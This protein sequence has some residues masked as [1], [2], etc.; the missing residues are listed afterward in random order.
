MLLGLGLVQILEEIDVI[1]LT[2]LHGTESR[3]IDR[4]TSTRFATTIS[5][6][7]GSRGRTSYSTGRGFDLDFRSSLVYT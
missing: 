6:E 7:H 2:F 5:I 1:C 3:D 4:R